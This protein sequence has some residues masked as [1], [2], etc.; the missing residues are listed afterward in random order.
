M[1]I[2][3]YASATFFYVKNFAKVVVLREMRNTD[4]VHK[5]GK[6]LL[7]H[8]WCLLVRVGCW[9]GG[10][11]AQSRE[12]FKLHIVYNWKTMNRFVNCQN[13]SKIL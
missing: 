8:V 12:L 10:V 13:L 6:I 11:C 4:R 3:D 7:L 2:I 5:K 1:Q 9:K